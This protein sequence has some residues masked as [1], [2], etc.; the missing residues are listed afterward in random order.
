VQ[1]ILNEVSDEIEVEIQEKDERI[2]SLEETVKKMREELE[3][4]KR[5]SAFVQNELETTQE[6]FQE[7]LDQQGIF[8][9]FFLF[10][11]QKSNFLF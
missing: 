4:E 7:V 6:A 1:R 9:F 8:S 10:F 3:K 5:K 2:S 11:F